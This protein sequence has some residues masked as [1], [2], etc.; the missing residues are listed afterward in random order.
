MVRWLLL[1]ILT[2]SMCP[3][4]LFLEFDEQQTDL[5]A[6]TILRQTFN[7]P[8][9]ANPCWL[10][11]EVGATDKETTLTRLEENGVEKIKSVGEKFDPNIHEAVQVVETEDEPD[12]TVVEEVRA[13]FLLNGRLLRPAQVKVAKNISE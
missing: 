8:E 12:D 6:T 13:G 9:C 1:L 4:V 10:G 11:I 5:D 3:G 2:L 7:R